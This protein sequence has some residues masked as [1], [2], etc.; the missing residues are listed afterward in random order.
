MERDA[1]N[2]TVVMSSEYQS[3][4]NRL[5]SDSTLLLQDTCH[6][7]KSRT[8]NELKRT[9]S[10]P[11]GSP[12]P[13][14]RTR[15]SIMIPESYPIDQNNNDLFEAT[16]SPHQLNDIS[17][18]HQTRAKPIRRS[19]SIELHREVYVKKSP[20]TRNH[21]CNKC[22]GPAE[23]LCGACRK[24]WYCTQRCQVKQDSFLV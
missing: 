12:A 10:H 15:T 2:E 3:R 6:Y 13:S 11:F 19:H 20:S 24:T 7:G 18:Y 4:R 16:V 17:R 21:R 5:H 23:F 1:Y 14:K 22:N 9:F 8:H